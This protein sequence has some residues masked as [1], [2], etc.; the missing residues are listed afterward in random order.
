MA[1]NIAKQGYISVAV[2]NA[3]AGEAADLEPLTGTVMIMILRHAFCWNWDG[4][5]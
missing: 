4:A 2:D 3:A 1:L 5:I